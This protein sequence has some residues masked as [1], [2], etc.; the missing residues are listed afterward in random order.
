MAQVSGE[1][2]EGTLP[3][4]CPENL[5]FHELCCNPGDPWPG[6]LPGRSPLGS[7]H[8]GGILKQGWEAL[9]CLPLAW[10]ASESRAG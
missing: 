9:F 8:R 6:V 1:Q 5:L 10:P 4:V 2:T 7:L 3:C